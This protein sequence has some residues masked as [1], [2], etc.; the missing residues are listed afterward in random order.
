MVVMEVVMED[1][2]DMGGIVDMGVM[3]RHLIDLEW[4]ETINREDLWNLH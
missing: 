1:L 3:A 2:A 4:M